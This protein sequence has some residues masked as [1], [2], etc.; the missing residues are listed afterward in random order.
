M[1]GSHST[2]LLFEKLPEI[3]PEGSQSTDCEIKDAI[4]SVYQNL[5]KLDSYISFLVRASI[6]CYLIKFW[7]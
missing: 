4:N 3:N 2:P 1:D 7:K 6:L 5:D